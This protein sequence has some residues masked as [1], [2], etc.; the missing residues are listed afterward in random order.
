MPEKPQGEQRARQLA[1]PIQILRLV[2]R[3]LAPEIRGRH[4]RAVGQR[5]V[6]GRERNV[7]ETSIR[8]CDLAF[9]AGIV[10][11]VAKHGFAQFDRLAKVDGSFTRSIIRL[12]SGGTLQYLCIGK[13]YVGGIR[14]AELRL[15][16]I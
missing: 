8:R 6:L 15:G 10:R 2:T 13:A 4:K 16:E 14:V 3:E 9:A 11:I 1:A 5:I 7:R 12:D